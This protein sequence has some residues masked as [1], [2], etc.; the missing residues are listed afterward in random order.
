MKRGGSLLI[1]KKYWIRVRDLIDEFKHSLAKI[2]SEMQ[3]EIDNSKIEFLFKNGKC[4]GIKEDDR[5]IKE[6]E[7][8]N[9]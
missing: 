2:E 7:L 8:D 3:E 1:Y 5:V 4:T 9:N 6:E